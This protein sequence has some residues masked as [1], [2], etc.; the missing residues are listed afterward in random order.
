[1]ESALTNLFASAKTLVAETLGIGLEKDPE[2]ERWTE[3][4]VRLETK[5]MGIR[6]LVMTLAH[7]II[8]T[9]RTANAVAEEVVAFYGAS[10]ARKRTAKRFADVQLEVGLVVDK[11]FKEQFGW[12]VVSLFDKWNE[13]IAAVKSRINQFSE[14]RV[15][16]AN[17]EAKLALMQQRKSTPA[18]EVQKAESQVEALKA[19]LQDSRVRVREHVKRAID[20]RFAAF[21]AIFIRLMEMQ[22]DYFRIG[23]GLVD[24]FGNAVETYRKHFPKSNGFASSDVLSPEHIGSSVSLNEQKVVAEKQEEK[25]QKDQESKIDV[26]E[27][28]HEGTTSVKKGSVRISVASPPKVAQTASVLQAEPV[29]KQVSD[30][31]QKEMNFSPTF[32][33]QNKSDNEDSIALNISKDQAAH[34]HTVNKGLQSSQ[35]QDFLNLFGPP[36]KPSGSASQAMPASISNL[37]IPVNGTASYARAPASQIG[38]LALNSNSNDIFRFDAISGLQPP[39]SAPVSNKYSNAASLSTGL[40]DF[41]DFFSQPAKVS[42]VGGNISLAASPPLL[43]QKQTGKDATSKV[44]KYKQDRL[45]EEQRELDKYNLS[46]AIQERVDRWFEFCLSLYACRSTKNKAQKNLRALLLTLNEI[47]WPDSGWVP[48]SMADLTEANA[49]KQIY[50]RYNDSICTY[51]CSKVLPLVHP[52]KHRQK[53]MEVQILSQCVSDILVKAWAIFKVQENV[54]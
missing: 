15:T 46:D 29:H 21:D 5:I 6:K 40:G 51:L 34:F 27:S 53:A 10:E 16:V 49:V 13:E 36:S 24:D 22:M 54:D 31:F 26:I 28:V 37:T 32:L 30:E 2:T 42:S 41:N 38:N 43:S 33:N 1:M 39:S 8:D 19:D 7:S 3:N 52:D 48:L 11:V 17:V 20:G 9:A 45:E 14:Q 12:D 23:S 47:L 4:L 44:D 25:K 18:G 50:K 35:E